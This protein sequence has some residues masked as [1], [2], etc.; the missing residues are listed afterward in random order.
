M[1]K[2]NK[3][4]KQ[5]QITS[6]IFPV[7]IGEGKSIYS[8][9]KDKKIILAELRRKLG[10]KKIRMLYNEDLNVKL[11]V[12]L[13][14]PFPSILEVS[15]IVINLLEGTFFKNKKQIKSL[16]M[17]LKNSKIVPFYSEPFI[18]ITIS[19][20][21]DLNEQIDNEKYQLGCFPYKYERELEEKGIGKNGVK[22]D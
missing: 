22:S 18:G 20:A 15:R 2:R 7:D 9:I 8:L 13:N 14:L 10:E 4:R 21:P 1:K 5:K 16:D 19:K 3:K 12:V 6:L 11:E 17:K